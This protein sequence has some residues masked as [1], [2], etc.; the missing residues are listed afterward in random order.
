MHLTALDVANAW[1]LQ[2]VNNITTFPFARE[3]RVTCTDGSCS[4]SYNVKYVA[5]RR[6]EAARAAGARSK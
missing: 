3:G 4:N 1:I 5:D 6:T 2:L